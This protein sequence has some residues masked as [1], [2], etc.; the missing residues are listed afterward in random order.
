[1]N[2]QMTDEFLNIKTCNLNPVDT[3]N[4][5]KEHVTFSRRFLSKVTYSKSYTD[6]GSCHTRCR[7]AHQEQFGVQ[8]LAQGHFNM[9]TRLTEPATFR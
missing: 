1:M 3:Q 5:M 6:G 2:L 9:Q 7:P 8:Y 4:E